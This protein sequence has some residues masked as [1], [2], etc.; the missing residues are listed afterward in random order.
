M[1]TFTLHCGNRLRFLLFMASAVYLDTWKLNIRMLDRILWRSYSAQ[2]TGA[3]WP[4]ER[5]ATCGFDLHSCNKLRI[6]NW[7]LHVSKRLQSEDL[8]LFPYLAPF[9]L[10]LWCVCVVCTN[11]QMYKCVK[12]QLMEPRDGTQVVRVDGRC[13]YQRSPLTGSHPTTL[14]V[15]Y[16]TS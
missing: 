1:P 6:Q 15:E 3:W 16:F 10:S 8:K 9:S 7:K 13:L 5:N 11:D 2:S 4:E 14:D 12:V